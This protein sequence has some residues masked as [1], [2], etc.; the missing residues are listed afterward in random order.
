MHFT[1]KRPQSFYEGK[2][3]EG[4]RKALNV[5]KANQQVTQAVPRGKTLGKLI[6]F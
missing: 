1:G 6:H 4:M 3:T 5:E 2:L